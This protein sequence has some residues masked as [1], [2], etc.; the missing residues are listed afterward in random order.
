MYKKISAVSLLFFWFLSSAQ[1]AV[2]NF[3]DFYNSNGN[4]L[5]AS[6][7]YFELRDDGYNPIP[8]PLF[9]ETDMKAGESKSKKVKVTKEGA[10]DFSY[11]IYFSKTAGDD[12]L[13]NVI[14]VEA[15]VDGSTVYTG[16]LSAINILPRPIITQ[17]MDDWEITISVPSDAGSDLKNKTCSFD[18][19]FKGWQANSNGSWG[20]SDSHTLSN[21]IVTTTWEDSEFSS[22]Q[23]ITSSQVTDFAVSDASAGLDPVLPTP[24]PS[25]TEES[26][27]SA[28]IEEPEVVTPE[29]TSNELIPAPTP[30]STPEAQSESEESGAL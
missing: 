19:T 2:A 5:S 3:A 28:S 7:L 17:A 6:S 22:G 15:K 21:S 11:N 29:V 30:E 4:N 12:A 10:E 23:S 8:N 25:D 1:I 24:A 20:F 26:T 27:P 13:C 9:S 14:Q 18:L 16:A